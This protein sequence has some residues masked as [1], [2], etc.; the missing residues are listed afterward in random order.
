M[1]DNVVGKQEVLTAANSLED[2]LNQ[3]TSH[4]SAYA[5]HT[6]D[7]H[8]SGMLTGAAGR[9]NVSTGT[10]IHDAIAKITARWTTAI[11]MLRNSVG[12]FDST[13]I[14]SASQ[15]TQVAGSMGGGLQW[16]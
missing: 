6:N 11:D 15:I 7:P 16:T 13:D 8:A 3:T 12:S 14:E 9:A 2:L 1:A 10:E 4:L 5:N